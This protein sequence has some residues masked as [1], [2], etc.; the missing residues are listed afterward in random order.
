MSKVLLAEDDQTMVTLLT[1]L[2]RME[3]FEV[4]ALASVSDVPGAVLQHRPDNLLIDY[5]L[6]RQNGIEVVE[7]IRSNSAN[8]NLN[9]VMASGLNVK[10]DCLSRGANHFI[11]KPFMPDDLIKLL[12]K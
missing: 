11:L 9:I 4:I 3:G 2:L 7:A 12:K 8:K 6:G 1:T 5:H 10:D